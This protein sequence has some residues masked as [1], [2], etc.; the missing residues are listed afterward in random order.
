M[1]FLKFERESKKESFL[2]KLFCSRTEDTKEDQK[3]MRHRSCI[4]MQVA[5]IIAL[6]NLKIATSQRKIDIPFVEDAVNIKELEQVVSAIWSKKKY[7]DKY[8]FFLSM[9][10]YY[11]E[12]G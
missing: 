12:V 3:G 1:A 8:V 9:T 4:L 11:K 2:G 6:R 10:K 7:F 5:C